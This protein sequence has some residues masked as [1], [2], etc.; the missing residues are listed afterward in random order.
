MAQ[1]RACAWL[2]G[3][4]GFGSARYDNREILARA[5]PRLV[6]AGPRYSPP[7]RE[8]DFSVI[9]VVDTPARAVAEVL[10]GAV[11]AV[12]FRS[13]SSRL[14]GRD[15]MQSCAK[16]AFS[17]KAWGIAPGFCRDGCSKR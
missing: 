9:R 2:A 7:D 13:I 12:L 17:I 16:G 6:D 8:R 10:K 3:G 4:L 14:E 1:H 11:N 15:S 5:G